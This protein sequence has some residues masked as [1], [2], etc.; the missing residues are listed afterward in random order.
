MSLHR[1]EKF[2]AM[3]IGWI[4]EESEE[5]VGGETSICMVRAVV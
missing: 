4:K 2:K 1:I 5:I 3:C